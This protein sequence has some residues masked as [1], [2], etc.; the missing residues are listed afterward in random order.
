MPNVALVF[1][2]KRNTGDYHD[3]MNHQT[4]E[5]WFGDSLLPN[6]QN[7]SIIV[8]DNAS[9]HSRRKEPLPVKSWTKGKLIEWLANR[10]IDFPQGALKNELWEIVERHRPQNPCYVVDEMASKAGRFFER[11]LILVLTFMCLILV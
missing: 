5:E 10:G 8:M 11:E 1:K 9:Y 6:I 7:N 4:F 2:S 3:E